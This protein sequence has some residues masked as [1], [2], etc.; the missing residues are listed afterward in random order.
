MRAGRLAAV[1]LFAIISS[2]HSS[3]A[4]AQVIFSTGDGVCKLCGHSELD[5]QRYVHSFL[6]QLFF[7]NSVPRRT[8]VA[9]SLYLLTATYT[10]QGLRSPD[11]NFASVTISITAEVKN[12]LPTGNYHV[13]FTTPGGKTGTETYA[14]GKRKFSV[15]GKYAPGAV[16]DE[17]EGLVGGG[18]SGPGGRS[19]PAPGGLSPQS[20]HTPA[21][22]SRS[23]MEA[24]GN[25]TIVYCSTG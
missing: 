17:S 1:A 21:A 14:I 9:A 16:R 19:R 8:A 11:P 2:A 18:S 15:R 23:R 3:P 24:R 10:M 20:K 5:T 12:L 4:Q 6:N 22:C 13:T 7:P 25:E